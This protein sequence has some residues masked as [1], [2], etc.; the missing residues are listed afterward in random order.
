MEE[1]DGKDLKMHCLRV[2]EMTSRVRC[3]Q[4]VNRMRKDRVIQVVLQIISAITL[5]IAGRCMVFLAAG[6]F[7]EFPA[8]EGRWLGLLS[9]I[10]IFVVG[11][12]L[13]LL[14]SGGK[15]PSYLY[16]SGAYAVYVLIGIVPLERLDMKIQ[17]A[18]FVL[19]FIYHSSVVLGFI[20]MR[21]MDMFRTKM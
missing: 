3:C 12:N 14:S 2:C 5:L 17:I 13:E 10:A 18:L 4:D 20:Y 19:A 9:M 21:A 11:K 7:R 15:L 16:P 6:D 1:R 8:V